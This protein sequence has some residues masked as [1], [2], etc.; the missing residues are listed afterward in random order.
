MRR[1]RGGNGCAWLTVW[2]AP[3]NSDP[4]SYRLP[5]PGLLSGGCGGDYLRGILMQHRWNEQR[6]DG[7][8]STLSPNIS[9][10]RQ[11]I[12]LSLSRSL[13]RSLARRSPWY[14]RTGWLGVK[15]QLTYLFSRRCSVVLLFKVWSHL[16]PSSPI[17]S[18][19]RDRYML[20][21]LFPNCESHL[22]PVL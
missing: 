20:N 16:T 3:Y 11:T 18:Y 10:N 14:N 22:A 21:Y 15:H 8:G 2:A 1:W 7:G 17:L 12:C 6:T 4:D 13:A 5:D 9:K 19:F